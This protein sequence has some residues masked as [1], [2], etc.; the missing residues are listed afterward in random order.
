MSGQLATP[1]M[2]STASELPRT[3]QKM[4]IGP[5]KQISVRCRVKKKPSDL[6]IMENLQNTECHH[7][8]W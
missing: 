7:R 1:E 8:D 3:S 4:K 6:V 2:E 5:E